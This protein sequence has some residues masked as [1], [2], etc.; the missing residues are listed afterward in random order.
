MP[1]WVKAV[2]VNAVLDNIDD[3]AEMLRKEAKKTDNKLDD[4]I[5]DTFVDGLRIFLSAMK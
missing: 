4:V 5:V 3:V 1:I 2:I